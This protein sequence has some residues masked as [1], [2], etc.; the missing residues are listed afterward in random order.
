MELSNIEE[1]ILKTLW[2]S[3]KEKGNTD[4]S[5]KWLISEKNKEASFSELSK[6]GYVSVKDDKIRLLGKGEACAK[7]IVRRHRLAERLMV[8]I[9]Q[10]KENLIHKTA[11]QFEHMIQQEVE[12]SICVLLG[13]PRACP[14]GKPIP[15]GKCCL[16]SKWVVESSVKPLSALNTKQKGKIA[17]LHTGDDKKLQ[18][19]MVMG[20]LPGIKISLL[21]KVPSYVF[22]IGHTQVAVDKEM[23]SGIYVRLEK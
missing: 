11:C 23:A 2:V 21:H 14:H 16:E 12:E 19:L 5:I 15:Q 3:Q 22:Q 1:D 18:K 17:Y 9:L 13:H 7:N 20:A 4:T 6:I 8:D 10:L